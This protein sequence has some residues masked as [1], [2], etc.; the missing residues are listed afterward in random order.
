MKGA[1]WIPA[2]SFPTRITDSHLEYLLKS[3]T[4]AHMNMLRVWG[5]GLYESESFY[6][7]CDRHGILLVADEGPVIFVSCPST[8]TSNPEWLRNG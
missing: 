7:L 8:G 4:D 3:A 2:D 6:N 1:D 5:G